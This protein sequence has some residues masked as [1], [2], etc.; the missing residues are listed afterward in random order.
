MKKHLRMNWWKYIAVLLLPA[1]LWSTVFSLRE[2]PS[3]NER[4]RILFVGEGVNTTALQ[5]DLEAALPHLT[6]Q[7]VKEITVVQQIPDNVDYGQWLISRQFSYDILIISEPW[8]MGDMG[9][10]Y[11]SRLRE[12][13]LSHFPSVRQYCETV[14]GGRLPFALALTSVQTRLGDYLKMENASWLLFFSPESV[15]LGGENGKGNAADDAAIAA[16]RYLSE[17]KH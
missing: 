7:T 17:E 12:P 15:N 5:E 6:T 13:L 16:A 14:D 10:N 4:L 11:F 2:R 1:I 9:Q 8:R 3:G